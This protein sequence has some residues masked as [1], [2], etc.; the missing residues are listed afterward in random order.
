MDARQTDYS[1]SGLSTPYPSFP[2]PSS[3]AS[4]ADQASAAQYP[5]SQDP[6]ASS[7]YSASATPTSDYS[8][9]NPASARSGSFPEYIQ[10]PCQSSAQGANA[11]SM[12]QP[13]SP[14]M[15]IQ[16]GQASDHQSQQQLKSDDNV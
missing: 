2:E 16:D 14:S 8:S 5:Q 12:A 9:I 11:G 13:Q 1:Q 3:E 15:P 10:R 4:S 7:N 6:R